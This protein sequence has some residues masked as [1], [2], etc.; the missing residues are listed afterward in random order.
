MKE[1]CSRHVPVTLLGM[2]FCGESE[3]GAVGQPGAS[4]VKLQ[5]HIRRCTAR[6]L[7]QQ[8]AFAGGYPSTSLL[9]LLLWGVYSLRRYQVRSHLSMAQGKTSA[10]PRVKPSLS[11][12]LFKAMQFLCYV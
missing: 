6:E 12:F 7:L 10:R 9:P 4:G 3:N 8:S 2:S 11:L 1:L 5:P